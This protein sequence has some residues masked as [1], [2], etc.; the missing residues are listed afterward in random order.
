MKKVFLCLLVVALMSGLVACTQPV[1]S[2]VLRSEKQRVTSPDVNEAELA[3]LVDGNSAF[4]FN[5]YQALKETN[6]NIFYSPYSISAALA[7]TYAGARGETAQQMADTLHFALLEG[8]LH[9]SFNYLDKELCQRGKDK[10]YMISQPGRGPTT[11][12]VEGFRLNIVNA[13]WGQKDYKFLPDF[14]DILAENYGAGLRILNFR[15][16]PEE[17]RVTINKWAS[18]QTE[19]RIN[20]VLPPGVI[21]PLTRLIVANA[22][23]FNARWEHKF[24]ESMTHDDP[25]YL[26]DGSKVTV[27]MMNQKRKFSYAEGDT[28][29]AVRLPYLGGELAMVILL[30]REG[31]FAAFQ[32]SLEVQKLNTILGEMEPR[33]VK[34]AMPKFKFESGYGL[35]GTL[36]GLGMPDA[37]SQGVADF[38]GMTGNRELFV[39]SV[40]HKT[41]V[42]VDE[43]GTEAAAVTIIG[44]VMS[45]PPTPPPV[46]V[47]FIANR[48]FIFLIQDI[49]TGTILFIG[50][51]L[52]PAS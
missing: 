40:I 8:H 7:M 46:P 47:D 6:G 36:A 2:E 45:G 25:F 50:R 24:V 5:L 38:S 1:S 12:N 51:V 10:K 22:I 27:P 41:F 52:N 37:F 42:S 35:E 9:S 31:E 43:V 39:G 49:Q 14:L 48:P 28:Y 30:P 20:N 18:D 29:Q 11:E 4:A 32:Q 3:T 34:L 21:N 44:M 23:Y 26:M 16:A 19:G 33:E 17:S 15:E 13:L